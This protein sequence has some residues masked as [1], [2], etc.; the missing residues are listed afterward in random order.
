MAQEKEKPP[1]FKRAFRSVAVLKVVPPW[2]YCDSNLNSRVSVVCELAGSNFQ[3]LTACSADSTSTGWP[4]S[5]LVCLTCPPGVI[6]TSSFTVPLS[7]ILLAS[8]EYCGFG[9]ASILRFPS[10]RIPGAAQ[11]IAIPRVAR[12]AALNNSP[13]FIISVSFALERTISVTAELEPQTGSSLRLLKCFFG[14]VGIRQA[15]RYSTF[16]LR[17]RWKAPAEHTP[18][19][20][21]VSYPCRAIIRPWICLSPSRS[22]PWPCRPFPERPPSLL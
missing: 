15:R 18:Q 19:M 9:P 17:F 21:L 22:A 5:A 6:T 7:F 3:S 13:F 4:P 16:V 12:A 1:I 20:V 8:S 11:Q 14:R 10:A 2:P